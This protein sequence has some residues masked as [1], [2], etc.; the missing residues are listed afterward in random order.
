MPFFQMD[1]FFF[2]RLFL[3]SS[4]VTGNVKSVLDKVTESLRISDSSSLTLEGRTAKVPSQHYGSWIY[5]AYS[6]TK[7]GC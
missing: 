7:F 5:Q 3:M 2:V 1:S 6:S 4:V